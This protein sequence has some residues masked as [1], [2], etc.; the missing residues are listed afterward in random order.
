MPIYGTEVIDPE[1]P[2]VTINNLL[3]ER[4]C[5][6]CPEQ[7]NVYNKGKKQ[8]GYV[9]L[10]HGSFN[11]YF[12]ECSDVYLYNEH[13]ENTH[14]E[15]NSEEQRKHYLTLAANLLTMKFKLEYTKQ[16]LDEELAMY[17]KRNN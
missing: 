15:F 8:I 17:K 2:I 1:N 14:G 6:A 7:Y 4:T 9:R 13:L 3:F 10:R 12:P 11:V 16:R 5:P